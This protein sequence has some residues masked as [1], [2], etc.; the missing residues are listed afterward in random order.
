LQV[1][2]CDPYLKALSVFIAQ[3]KKRTK[4]VA[5]RH[6]FWAQN[7]PKI[8]LRPVLSPEPHWGWGAQRSPVPDPLAGFRG[9]LRGNEWRGTEKE[10]EEGRREGR[11][12]KV[13][14]L[15]GKRGRTLAW[16][17]WLTPWVE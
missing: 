2:L 11:Q 4:I 13:E 17:Q 8:L 6:D 12:R 5:T 7:V 1:T 16:C 3:H 10:G 15:R 9:P 14:G